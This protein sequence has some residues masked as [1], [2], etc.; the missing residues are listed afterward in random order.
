MNGPQNRKYFFNLLFIKEYRREK[1]TTLQQSER[2]AQSYM[3][4]G[5][6]TVYML[7][8]FTSDESIVVPFME[9]YIV[10]RLATMLDFNLV[11]LAGPR[12]ADLKV[13]NPEKYK[14]DPKKL[15]T[16]LCHVYIHLSHREEFINAVSKDGRSYDKNI[17]MRAIAILE[18]NSL[19][20]PVIF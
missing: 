14:F 1:E 10:D 16:D 15:L 17:F 2:Q 6:E 9:P 12:C 11:A 5:N 7:R 20:D 8:Y 3:S 18:K 13:L 4:L 19:I